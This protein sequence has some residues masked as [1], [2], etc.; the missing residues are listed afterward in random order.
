MS[1]P[2][3]WPEGTCGSPLSAAA[4]GAAGTSASAS[5]A[6]AALT[7]AVM[8]PSMSVPAKAPCGGGTLLTGKVPVKLE[9]SE[10]LTAGPRYKVAEGE[11]LD[12]ACSVF[13]AEGFDRAKQGAIAERAGTT[14]P[15][16]Y[17][18]FGS[19]EDLFAATVAREYDL[20]KAHLF[21]AYDADDGE[22]FHTRLHH[23]TAAY[24]D[25]VRERPE[26]FRLI[27]EGERYPAAAAIVKRTND[28]IVDRIAELVTRISGR[29]S[30][31]GARVVA[32]M[33]AGM[34]TA[35]AR[36]AAGR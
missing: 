3:R 36:E 19:K 17:A 33:I 8:R 21:A 29:R 2:G 32:S 12:A 16:L 13:A 30:R 20:R 23:W 1:G 34:L 22:P 27:T 6:R 11:I 24:F 18:R 15:T 25:F 35:C 10:H 31:R 9:A 5:T 26:G 14:K 4:A 28:E 7:R